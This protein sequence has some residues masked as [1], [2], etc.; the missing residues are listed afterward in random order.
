MY[1][2]DHILKPE[3]ALAVSWSWLNLNVNLF[4]SQC[5]GIFGGDLV[6]MSIE[7]KCGEKLKDFI[8]EKLYSSKKVVI[9]SPWIS[10]ET[11]EI[12]LDL[13]SKSVELITTNDPQPYHVRGLSALV[14]IEKK[15]VKEGNPRLAKLGLLL[16][17]VGLFTTWFYFVGLPLL[18]IGIV[19]AA[20]YRSIYQM[21]CGPKVRNVLVVTR[22]L[23][24]K[25]VVTDS[26]VGVGSLNFTEAGLTANI[27][28]FAWVY[29]P[30]TIRKA[31]EVVNELKS[32]LQKSSQ[33]IC[34]AVKHRVE[35]LPRKVRRRYRRTLVKRT[36]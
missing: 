1:A 20:R 8:I 33:D 28:C 13:V 12:I 9:V 15:L 7:L 32:E 31:V 11:A 2:P 24:A 19:L 17:V 10:K 21:M 36:R 4:G 16:I 25:L 30:S 35:A 3:S 27:E 26:A 22:N 14:S 5:N 6:F 34:S 29:D 18:I 23:H